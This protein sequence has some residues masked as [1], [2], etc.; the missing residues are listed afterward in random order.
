MH[1]CQWDMYKYNPI[2]QICSFLQPENRFESRIWP[3]KQPQ[4]KL[5]GLV[6]VLSVNSAKLSL[7]NYEEPYC[8]VNNGVCVDNCLQCDWFLPPLTSTHHLHIHWLTD[9]IHLVCKDV[10]MT[11]S[12]YLHSC[13]CV[14]VPV[15]VFLRGLMRSA[16]WQSTER[17]AFVCTAGP[18]MLSRLFCR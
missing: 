12:V 7:I 9:W 14:C 2:E 4:Y 18:V 17:G 5:Q 15:C 16:P 10:C 8:E 3:G 11:E 13:L 6:N 1:W